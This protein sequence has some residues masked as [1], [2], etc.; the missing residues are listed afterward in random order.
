MATGVRVALWRGSAVALLLC[1]VYCLVQWGD[2]SSPGATVAATSDSTSST[3]AADDVT[4]SAA[5]HL[6][7]RP[8]ALVIPAIGVDTLLVR[9]GQNRDST[10]EVP[11]DPDDAGWYRL[12]TRPGARGSA[13]ILG[14]VDSVHGPAVFA[15]LRTLEPGDLVDVR[16]AD[17]ASERFRVHSVRTYLNDDFPAQRVYA[18]RAGRLLNLVTCG[19]EYDAARGGYQ[20]NVVVQ[21]RWL[22]HTN[23]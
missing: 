9:L 7:A 17:G 4:S 21:A 16:T 18:A 10:V 12:G 8:V 2:S 19:G 13:V 23:G 5:P 14:H 6:P 3:P 20:A 15:R 22:S 11:A 1:A